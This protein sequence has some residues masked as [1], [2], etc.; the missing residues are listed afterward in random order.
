M[1]LIVGAGEAFASIRAL[2]DEMGVVD[3]MI[4]TRIY[5]STGEVEHS[6]CAQE[7][8]GKQGSSGS[9]ERDLRT[10][11]TRAYTSFSRRFSIHEPSL[12]G[13]GNV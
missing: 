4:L 13:T 1:Y 7:A 2:V 11:Q 9:P 10:S 6:L 5:V 12:Y 8:D 3:S